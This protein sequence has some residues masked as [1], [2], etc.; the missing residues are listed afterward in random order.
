MT[1]YDIIEQL[2]MQPHPRE[3]G[4]FSRTYISGKKL[5]MRKGERRLMSSI[6]YM[7]I[8]DQPL[9]YIHR[10]AS[11]VVHFHHMGGTLEYTLVSPMGD[12]TRT[13]L[14]SN[15][16]QGERLQL[17]VPGGYWKAS[18]LLSGEYGLIS[19]AVSPGFDFADNMIGKTAQLKALFPE[20]FEQIKHLIK[21][22]N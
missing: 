9:G 18:K 3:G 10:N 22:G 4:Y 11:D 5:A 2:Q 17:T 21:P 15:I 7:L 16:L 1:V 19:E 12:V 6:Y 13:K 8:S 14:G 20:Q